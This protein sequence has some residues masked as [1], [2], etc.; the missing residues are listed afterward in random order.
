MTNYKKIV[1]FFL[2]VLTLTAVTSSVSCGSDTGTTSETTPTTSAATEA[3]TEDPGPKLDLPEADYGGKTFNM[4]IP[5]EYSDHY[6]ADKETGD[7]VQDA[8]YNRNVA[9]EE[10]L[11]IKY[12]YISAMGGWEDRETYKGLIR[13][14]VLAGDG[15]YDLVAGYQVCVLPL[16]LEGVF[17]DIHEVPG[18]D[19]EKPWWVHNLTDTIGIQG[20]LYTIIGDASISLYSEIPVLYFNKKLLTDYNL[21]DPYP[22][23][24]DGTWTVDAL[25]NL[26]KDTHADLNG[27]GKMVFGEDAYGYTAVAVAQRAFQTATEFKVFDYDEDGLPC[28]VELAERD[29]DLYFKLIDFIT[30]PGVHAYGVTDHNEYITPFL[31]DQVLISNGFISHT[32]LL[33]DM[34]SDF[35]ILPLPKRDEAQENYHAQVGTAAAMFFVPETATDVTMTGYVAEAMNYYGYKE[36]IPAYFEI[37]LKEKYTRDETVKQMLDIVRES[38]QVNFTFAFSTVFDPFTNVILPTTSTESRAKDISSNF[39]S[40]AKRWQKTLDKLLEA[41]AEAES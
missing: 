26:V 33:R 38:A 36:V 9:V 12:N 23:V 8:V 18:I 10:L 13:N 21:P 3:V 35:G 15:A 17:M 5:T 29:A 2:A 40:Y 7:V 37:A 20:K 34:K 28:F 6:A 41:Y 39:A 24:L 16:S 4:L 1:S 32:N 31:S 27:D 14:S 30:G 19:M 25:I 22:M 11:N